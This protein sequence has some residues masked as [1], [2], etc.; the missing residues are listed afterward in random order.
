AGTA[1]PATRRSPQ[2]S[3]PRRLVPPNSAPARLLSQQL[4]PAALLLLVGT[5]TPPVR[6]RPA[7]TN[8]DIEVQHSRRMSGYDDVNRPKGG[9]CGS[10]RQHPQSPGG[11]GVIPVRASKIARRRAQANVSV[12]DR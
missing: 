5:C 3:S 7:W 6:F 2:A 8:L 11:L 12:G 9:G 1:G 10:Q 4:R